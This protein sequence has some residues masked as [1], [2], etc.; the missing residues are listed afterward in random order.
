M[1]GG[2]NNLMAYMRCQCRIFKQGGQVL[3]EL[4]SLG[5]NKESQVARSYKK[6][7]GASRRTKCQGVV[8]YK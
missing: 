3:K 1:A 2:K 6:E 8:G 7:Q 5:E 4:F